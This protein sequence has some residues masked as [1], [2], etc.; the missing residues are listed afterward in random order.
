MSKFR[1]SGHHRQN[2]HGTTFW[3]RSHD[4]SRDEWSHDANSNHVSNIKLSYRGSAYGI[5]YPRSC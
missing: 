1:R 4:V 5:T 2:Q 3:V